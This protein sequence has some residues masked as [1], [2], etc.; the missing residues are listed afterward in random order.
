MQTATFGL[1]LQHR[2]LLGCE[3]FA[4][5][6]LDR[7]VDRLEARHQLL[8]DRV[9][10]R[11]TTL[12]DGGDLSPLFLSQIEMCEGWRQFAHLTKRRGRF[13]PQR[14]DSLACPTSKDTDKEH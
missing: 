11:T 2:R 3:D 5:L 4:N 12:E 7:L 1:F 13:S 10:P 9:S 14:A 8:E 6:G